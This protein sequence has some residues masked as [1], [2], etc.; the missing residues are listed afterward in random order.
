MRG[1][2]LIELMVSI[3]IFSVVMTT[4]LG[5]LLAISYADRKAESLRT[6]MDNLNFAMEGMS[7]SIR[8]GVN[9]HCGTTG[10][11]TNAQDCA[12]TGSTFFVFLANDNYYTAYC[13]NNNSIMRLRVLAAASLRTTCSAA[14]GF[15]PITATEISITD[16]RFLTRGAPRGDDLQPIV[17][18]NIEG[19]ISI[20][21]NNTSAFALQTSMVQ[22]IYDQ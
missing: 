16:L 22:R 11:L 5:S 10:T 18:L 13:L 14:D 19:S 2:T 1:F 17:T 15:L 9:Y 3:A 20:N 12:A 21:A 4:A 8:T 7:R 6:V